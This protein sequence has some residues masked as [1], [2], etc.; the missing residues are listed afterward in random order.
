MSDIMRPMP[1][2]QLMRWILG[3]YRKNGTIFGVRHIVKH[4]NGQARPVFNEKIEAV[5][6]PAAGPHTQLAQNIVA[7][8]VSGSRFFELKTVQIMDGAELSEC[9]PKPCIL[10]QDEGYNCEWSTELTVGQAL[11]EYIH[12]WIACKLLAR[13]LG[14]G[15]PD[16]F[17]FNMS[18][19]YDLAG[20]KSP[21]IDAFIEGMKDA[22]RQPAFQEAIGWALAHQDLFENVDETYIRSISSHI[23]G[24][25]TESTLHGCLP[26]EIEAIAAYLMKEKGLHT[27]VK[28]NPTLLGYDYAREELDR[29][30]FSYVSFDRHHFQEDLQWEDAA[31]MFRRLSALAQD[32]GLQFG[33]KLTNTFPVEAQG[34][35]PSQE[36]YMSGRALFPLTLEL[37]ARIAGE[38][39]GKLR[40]S[41]S[42]GADINSIR[43]LVDA[44]IWPVTMATNILKP[45]GYE[46]LAQ[47]GNLLMDCGSDPFTGVDEE[48]LKKLAQ[49]SLASGLYSQGVKPPA[50]RHIG[51]ALPLLDCM[52]APC[53]TSC[54]IG[55]DIP[56]Y[57]QAVSQG[58]PLQALRII[59]ERNALPFITGTI[60]PHT[61]SGRCMR[62]YYEEGIHIR[63]M[64]LLA[65][66]QAYGD[67][68]KELKPAAAWRRD[69]KA[70]VVG[71]GPAGLS[72]AFF[73]TRAGI[74][75]TVFEKK[76]KP[77]GIV[78]YVI[79]GF[80][81]SEEAI[82]R[83]VDLCRAYGAEFVTGREVRSLQEL[84][85]EGFTDI[86]VCAGAWLPG[87]DVLQYGKALDCLDFLTAVKSNPDQ[88]RPGEDVCIIGAGN[89]AMDAARTAKRLPG[90]KTVTIVYRRT[91]Q[92]MPADQEEYDLA[93]KEGVLFRELLSPVGLRD[94]RLICDIMELGQA[95]ESGRR[96][97]VKTGKTLE[98]ACSCLIA[99]AGERADTSLLTEAGAETDSRGRLIVG[100]DMQTTIPHV[101]AAGDCRQ[102]PATVVKAIADAAAAA[103]SI[104]GEGYDRYLSFNAAYNKEVYRDK[105]GQ[106][107]QV[108]EDKYDRRC[109]GCPTVCEVC[110]DVCPNRA[111]AAVTVPGMAQSQIVHIDSMCNECG[112]CAVFCPWEGRP[113]R[114]KLTLFGSREDFENSD[115]QGFLP[116]KDGLLVRLDGNVLQT[117]LSGSGLPDKVRAL[118][119]AVLEDYPYTISKE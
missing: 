100:E 70:A 46:R 105:K 119:R 82:D 16:G 97:P 69:R 56:A 26:E 83:D 109:L 8:Y 15:D 73:L 41:Y 111:N 59:T 40:I 10:A 114:D 90:V 63:D 36:M 84:R 113:Y 89:S 45:G 95:D 24:S 37:S 27:Y 43:D 34:K 22:S 66:S 92:Y 101:Y 112:N 30:G 64:K 72:A 80:R 50:D 107:V 2:G 33:L 32:L 98:L 74:R 81:I 76:E 60:C 6:G 19:G 12:A 79:P 53:R 93:V 48:K 85:D 39:G 17:V 65:A 21:K 14:L 106:I 5:F 55:Q 57:L 31:A 78:R 20:I 28:C 23:S 94:G 44:G 9:V 87:A 88:V 38:F 116:G 117:D 51:K 118:I 102:G 103:R 3:E 115:N 96:A 11:T 77:G 7:A 68:M 35:L 49:K 75:T 4:E 86:I 42:G 61:C 29:L 91:R 13:E 71:G 25:V 62:G 108:M 18:V 1:F 52:T 99:A 104:S 54:P 58:R 47:I 67:L 110:A